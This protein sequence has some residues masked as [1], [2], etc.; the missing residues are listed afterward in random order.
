MSSDSSKPRSSQGTELGRCRM[1]RVRS[2]PG[3]TWGQFAAQR[4][5]WDGHHRGSTGYEY[6]MYFSKTAAGGG[7]WTQ[8]RGAFALLWEQAAAVQTFPT[9][10]ASETWQQLPEGQE[11]SSAS[12]AL[13]SLAMM[14]QL[15]QARPRLPLAWRN[16]LL[17]SRAETSRAIHLC[18]WMPSAS[19]HHLLG[20]HVLCCLLAISQPFSP[21]QRDAETGCGDWCKISCARMSVLGFFRA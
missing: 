7:C 3:C 18:W 16:G 14:L 13:H 10:P 12:L 20:D 1:Q 6:R 21:S 15:L 2:V 8:P 19:Q 4:S 17:F 11:G 9:S 5:W